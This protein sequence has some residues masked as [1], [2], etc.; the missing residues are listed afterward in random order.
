MLLILSEKKTIKDSLTSQL[1]V[2]Y[3]FCCTWLWREVCA[4]AEDRRSSLPQA[5]PVLSPWRPTD[6]EEKHSRLPNLLFCPASDSS[7]AH[8]LILHRKL[9]NPGHK[10][11]RSSGELSSI[12]GGGRSAELSQNLVRVLLHWSPVGSRSLVLGLHLQSDCTSSGGSRAKTWWIYILKEM[13][14][15]SNLWIEKKRMSCKTTI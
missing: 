11:A 13:Q 9:L 15:L 12:E 2:T 4:P 5:D 8:L 1:Q 3:W 10:S 6:A 7:D 14:Q